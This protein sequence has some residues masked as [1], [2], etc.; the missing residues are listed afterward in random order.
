M[1]IPQVW[2]VWDSAEVRWALR[3]P[4]QHHQ[5]EDLCLPL[6]LVRHPGHHHWYPGAGTVQ[7]TP[8]QSNSVVDSDLTFVDRHAN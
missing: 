5:R 6:V 7:P 3:P 1:H 8:D 2:S 4:S